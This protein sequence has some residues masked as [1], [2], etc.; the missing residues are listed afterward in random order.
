MSNI[1]LK[2]PVYFRNPLPPHFSNIGL[3]VRAVSNHFCNFPK[4][5]IWHSHPL[6]VLKAS[7][8]EVRKEPEL[9]LSFFF[10]LGKAVC[11]P[12]FPYLNY[13]SSLPS[14]WQLAFCSSF[15]SW[16]SML[17]SKM[18]RRICADLPFRGLGRKWAAGLFFLTWF[19]F[20]ISP[21]LFRPRYQPLPDCCCRYIM[22]E[23]V[24]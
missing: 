2:L 18:W 7:C 13:T 9:E 17:N 16:A 3:G 20:M 12:L 5:T 14:L 21:S 23:Y 8:V 6:H 4:T 15:L 22:E 19:P 11:V 10:I 1:A 24:T